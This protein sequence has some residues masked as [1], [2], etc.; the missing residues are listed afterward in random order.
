MIGIGS[1]VT[2]AAK[3]RLLALGLATASVAVLSVAPAHANSAAVDYF[4]TR[5]DRTAVPSL[6]SQDEREYY[7]SLFDAI[8]R[9][10][11][12][13]VQTLFAQKDD[14]PLQREAL[15]ECLLAPGSPRV[16][17]HHQN[18]WLAKGTSLPQS[19]QFA[20]LAMTRGATA[21]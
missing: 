20:R 6:L 12:T 3:A 7:R 13:R 11:W 2:F 18:S 19:E 5:A 14:G 1:H 8:E 15:A 21:T 4:R 10:D 16:G 17:V 9:K